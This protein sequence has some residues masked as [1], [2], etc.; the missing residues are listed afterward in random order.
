M[1]PYS[2]YKEPKVK[3]LGNIPLHWEEKRAKYYF[4][5]I[6]IRSESGN[7]EMLSVSH[8]TGVSPRSEKNVTMFLSETNVGQKKCRPGD[9]VINT[10]WAWMAA[11]GISKYDGIVSPSYGVYRPIDSKK[12]NQIYLDHL[13]RTEGY[14]TEYYCRSTGIRSS[15]LRLYPDKFLS[16][17][18]ICPPLE[19][20]NKIVNYLN[21]K[22]SKINSF[23]KAK[24]KLLI[25]LE[26]TRNFITN[27][28]L[29]E[30]NIEEK[31]LQYVVK[32]I[33]R[34]VIRISSEIYA[35]I[36]LYNRGR[37]IFVKPKLLGKEL[38][39][40]TFFWIEEG[41][42]V[43]SGQFA[44]E[45]AVSIA[46]K[47]EHGCI[48]SH[49]FPILRGDDISVKT[50]FLWA[51]FQTELGYLLL[52][53]HSRG[54]A[55]RNKPLNLGTLL[56]EKIPIPPLNLQN[57]IEKVITQEMSLRIEIKRIERLLVEYKARLISDLVT[58][59]IDVRSIIIP[60]FEQV[61]TELNISEDVSSFEELVI[62]ED[63]EE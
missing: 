34:P 21:W 56:K 18:I 22:L 16:I 28:A 26:E 20:Q 41:D 45:G 49:R 38:G 33:K 35:P 9:L 24:R 37:G 54:A 40:S 55:G 62:G 7:E 63:I 61:E 14:R 5:E 30:S 3:W 6:D 13:L 11:L 12:F 2:Q 53:N 57:K 19:E 32:Q 51:F 50:S 39:D 43:L 58:G 25:L 27:K 10:M 59:K 1:K 46:T 44:W 52:N 4:K 48:A 23:I 17:P 8:I 36:G 42:L 60:N 31:R 29:S 47:I 15:R